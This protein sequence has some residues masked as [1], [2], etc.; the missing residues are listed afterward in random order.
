[1]RAG[2]AVIAKILKTHVVHL[3]A[4]DDGLLVVTFPEFTDYE[5]F[6]SYTS[7]HLSFVMG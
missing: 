7:I 6:S 2:V 3:L 5:R 1:M 4:E